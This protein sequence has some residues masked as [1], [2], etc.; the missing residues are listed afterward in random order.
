[1]S[2]PRGPS[3]VEQTLRSQRESWRD[4][5]DRVAQISN[6]DLPFDAPKRVILFGVGSSHFAARLTALSLIRDKS[7]PRIPV[8]ACSSTAIPTEVVPAR[9]DW[10]FAFSHRAGGG[11]TIEALDFASRA[12]AMT[13]LVCGKGAPQPEAAKYMLETVEL[14]KVEPH[15]ASVTGAVCAVTSLLVGQKAVEEWDALRSIGDPDLDVFCR[16]AGKGPSVLLGEWEG[17]WLAREAALKLNEMA[18]LQPRAFGSEE[19]FHGPH[20]AQTADDVIWHVSVPR[21]PRASQI[22]AAHSIGIFG[23][24]PLAWVPALIELQWLALATAINRGVDPDHPEKRL[25]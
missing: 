8:V 3:I 14:E 19:Y 16:R 5:Y 13:I 15:T 10:V 20:F 2:E 17:E 25:K 18:G 9:G 6:R 11:P 24:T 4:I 12:G 22:R 1:M 7:R 23:A 21:D